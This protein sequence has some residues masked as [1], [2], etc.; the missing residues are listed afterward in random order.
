M[1]VATSSEYDAGNW[2]KC[3]EG[4]SGENMATALLA[5]ILRQD[6]MAFQTAA[7]VFGAPDCDIT[8][9]EV[10]TEMASGA[11]DGAGRID[12]VLKTRSHLI[13]VEVK[14][15]AAFQEG[16]PYKYLKGLR[17]KTATA[18]STRL[19]VLAPERRKDDVPQPPHGEEAASFVGWEELLERLSIAAD[20]PGQALL[21]FMI[22]GLRRYYQDYADPFAWLTGEDDSKAVLLEAD[23]A[24]FEPLARR[25]LLSLRA[26]MPS[27]TG[28]KAAR[29]GSS[30]GSY[31]GF[32]VILGAERNGRTGFVGFV[33]REKYLRPGSPLPDTQSP[34]ALVLC[35]PED[36]PPFLGR[37]DLG[38]VLV[39][40]GNPNTSIK[41][42]IRHRQRDGQVLVAA[43]LLPSPQPGDY[44][45]MW[46]ER[47][48]AVFATPEALE[49]SAA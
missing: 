29:L 5:V 8:E 35:L 44:T 41:G 43:A 12:L 18:G 13:G 42:I 6:R 11:G 23:W 45:T 48:T 32:D 33:D 10:L 49:G 46:S 38:L 28:A 40:S 30:V 21:Q 25:Y 17:T 39:E 14:L 16:Q 4:L 22:K 34:W 15:G 20:H 3:I 36:C 24:K 27:D 47:L 1:T 37:I 26:L 31:I 7:K 2:L 19:A 9:Y